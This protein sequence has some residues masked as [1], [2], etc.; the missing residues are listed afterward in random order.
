MRTEFSYGKR[1]QQQ[2]EEKSWT[3]E[4]LA[5]AADVDVRTIQRVEKDQ[6]KNA[7]TIQAIAG[8][9]DVGVE[10][11]RTTRLIPETRL[12]GTWLA[13]SHREFLSVERT[14][15]SHQL[16]RMTVSPLTE[17]GQE[18]VDCL[19]RQVYADRQYF[20]P[21][22]QE[23]WDCYEQQ[24]QDPLRELFE[25]GQAIF[26]IDECKD[27]ILSDCGQLKP[28]QRCI[29]N[30]HVLYHLVVPRHGCFQVD[31]EKPMHRFNPLCREA[32]ETLLLRIIK[33]VQGS[34]L[35]YSNALFAL[36]HPGDESRIQW[37]DTC[38][39]LGSDG[40]RFGIDYITE[41]TGKDQAE[42]YAD[43]LEATGNSF[44][45]GLS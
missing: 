41:V 7:E 43:Y 9:L 1:V 11:L 16:A 23:L 22:D 33:S 27:F 35:V 42:L 13:T 3:Q 30:W 32:G 28:I 25:L 38:F 31:Q 10:G 2:R 18:R 21:E 40:L 12:A 6:T 26:V 14:R 17:E 45:V 20:E 24:V 15:R 37:C 19:L 36:R 39:P 8:A 5:D 44:I 34:A 29:D 4:Q